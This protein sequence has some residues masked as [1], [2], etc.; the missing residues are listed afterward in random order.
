MQECN[1]SIEE[2]LTVS[3]PAAS[4]NVR[5]SATT[6]LVQVQVPP[7][8]LTATNS[9]RAI[10]TYY[11]SEQQHSLSKS[12]KHILA[13]APRCAV[14]SPQRLALPPLV[15]RTGTIPMP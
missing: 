4:E 6:V 1:Q 3:Y 5:H 9:P 15:M 10:P 13:H 7:V 8:T 2:S 11:A 14:S 12:Q